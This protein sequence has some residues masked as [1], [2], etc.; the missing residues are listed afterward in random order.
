MSERA[1][2]EIHPVPT[3]R[4]RGRRRPSVGTRRRDGRPRNPLARPLLNPPA[5][6]NVDVDVGARSAPDVSRS[7]RVRTFGTHAFYSSLIEEISMEYEC[8][9]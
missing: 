2:S 7:R 3:A 8:V 9:R 6:A 5:D 1:D 4:R